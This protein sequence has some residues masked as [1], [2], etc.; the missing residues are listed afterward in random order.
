MR[1]VV[2]VIRS[3][4]AAN[5]SFGRCFKDGVFEI[6]QL[7]HHLRNDRSAPIQR[8]DAVLPEIVAQRTADVD[9]IELVVVAFVGESR[10]DSIVFVTDDRRVVS[11]CIDVVEFASGF[12][13]VSI[14][15]EIDQGA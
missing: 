5:F 15:R 13:P 10:G 7:V 6:G 2:R 14:H 1:S 8:E 12:L 11:N 3:R 9:E 4:I